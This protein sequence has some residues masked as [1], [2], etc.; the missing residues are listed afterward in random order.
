MAIAMAGAAMSLMGGTAQAAVTFT[1]TSVSSAYSS[2]PTGDIYKT[3][4][5]TASYNDTK[6]VPQI[7]T[8]KF[9]TNPSQVVNIFG[10]CVDIFQYSG[11]TTFQVVTLADYLGPTKTTQFNEITAL[12]A[13]EGNNKSKLHDASMQAA[14]WELLYETQPTLDIDKITTTQKVWNGWKWVNQTTTPSQF[15]IDDVKNGSGVLSTADSFLS[16]AVADA[17]KPKT[18]Y[19]F[20]VLKSDT[21]QDFLYWTY[22][23]PSVPEPATWGMMLLGLGAVGYAMRTSRRTAVSFS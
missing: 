13:D 16:L 9:S 2:A 11:A 20:Y 6:L 5:P 1:A 10:Y 23:P 3:S 19:N 4:S 8:G 22:T 14:I 18:G 21:K 15:Y 7:I 12:I 17:G